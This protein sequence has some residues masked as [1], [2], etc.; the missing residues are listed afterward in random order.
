MSLARSYGVAG[1]ICLDCKKTLPGNPPLPER[2]RRRGRSSR[3]AS[4]WWFCLEFVGSP[5]MFTLQS[6]S[7]SQVNWNQGNCWK[8]TFY[9]FKINLYDFPLSSNL[10][11]H[12]SF[13]NQWMVKLF[14]SL[15]MHQF[16]KFK[17]TLIKI[18]LNEFD[19]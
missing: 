13:D 6:S 2:W 5:T 8:N 11:S 19:I 14:V 16:C 3:W 15:K 10:N 7:F 1:I 4:L 9:N 17:K 12:K 18:K